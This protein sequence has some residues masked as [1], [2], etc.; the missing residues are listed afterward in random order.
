M[1]EPSEKYSDTP[2]AIAQAELESL[3]PGRKVYERKSG[4]FF[5]SSKEEALKNV[6][7]RREAATKKAESDKPTQRQ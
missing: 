3:K 1:A 2:D 7:K 6:E 5:L 4:V